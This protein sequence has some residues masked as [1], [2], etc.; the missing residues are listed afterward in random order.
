MQ[1]NLKNIFT[2]L[3][4]SLLSILK[5]LIQSRAV[6]SLP[7]P[8]EGVQEVVVL[9]NGPSLR[10]FIEKKRAF[11]EGRELLAVNY[12]VLSD[13]FTALKPRYYVLADP[14]FFLEK[15][16]REK[17]F[18]RLG[19]EVNWEMYLF[20][21]VDARKNRLWQEF[22]PQN[23]RI[24]IHYFNMT[25]VDGF[26]FFR[27]LAYRKGWGMP[28]PRNVL[29]PSIMIALRMNFSTLYVAGADHS[30]MREYWVNDENRVVED[31]N[32]FYDKGQSVR[33]VSPF[34]LHRLLESMATAFRSYHLIQKFA[35]TQHK[36]IIN[37]TEGSFI[38]AF[39]RLKVEETPQ[40][41]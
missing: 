6:S 17:V 38:D 14:A 40:Q 5:M 29:I 32:H 7:V 24:R 9:G 28:R 31:L 18:S 21:P 13:Y 36:R 26:T 11:F 33:Y 12:A 41:V 2:Q 34:P 16:H 19:Q 3:W 27:H 22:I 10:P 23:S 35:L 39:D 4:Q 20:L 37:I 30:W 1:E 15:S 25:P 8:V